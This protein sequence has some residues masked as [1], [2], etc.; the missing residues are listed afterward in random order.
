MIKYKIIRRIL[1][2]VAVLSLLALNGL[3]YFN[4]QPA[5]LI[6]PGNNIVSPADGRLIYQ[7]FISQNT[8]EFFKGEIKNTLDLK[9][10]TPPLTVLVIEL[11]LFNVHW[12]RAPIAGQVV[13]QQYFPGRFKNAV[14]SKDK[15]ELV[16]ANEKLLTVI[17]NDKI[18][19]GVVQVAGQAARR[20][21][22]AVSAN[23]SVTKG[24]P[25]GQIMLGSQVVLIIPGNLK[26]LPQIG[27]AVMDGQTIIA[28]Y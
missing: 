8:V 24:Q 17:E 6:P 5:R 15:N 14:F 25:I 4:R 28:E 10:F 9:N 22:S 2:S 23:Q 16:N 19:V 3:F 11:N 7:T 12:Q 26:I 1:I 20:I 13:Y 18:K 21:K 27:Q